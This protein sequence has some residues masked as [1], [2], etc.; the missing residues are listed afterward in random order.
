M[1]YLSLVDLTN[2][3][4]TYGLG[5]FSAGLPM[6]SVPHLYHTLKSGFDSFKA[7]LAKTRTSL[8]TELDGVKAWVEHVETTTQTDLQSLE[9]RITA[10]E[11]AAKAAL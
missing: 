4:V 7:E 5:F 2:P 8:G 9:A 1:N 3:Q 11:N 10:L 6:M